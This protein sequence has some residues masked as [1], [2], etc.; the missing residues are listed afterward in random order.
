METVSTWN[1]HF[2]LKSFQ[3]F[4]H[5]TAGWFTTH[6]GTVRPQVVQRVALHCPLEWRPIRRKGSAKF[7]GLDGWKRYWLCC[8]FPWVQ[9][10]LR[11]SMGNTACL[12]GIFNQVPVNKVTSHSCQGWLCHV[13]PW[14]AR[15]LIGFWF[16]VISPSLF[17]FPM[18]AWLGKK[19][20]HLP[21]L[22]NCMT[23]SEASR[24]RNQ[25]KACCS[26]QQQSLQGPASMFESQPRLECCWR[27]P[28]PRSNWLRALVVTGPMPGVFSCAML[29][30]THHHGW[31]CLRMG[32]MENVNHVWW[33][34]WCKIEGRLPLK[35]GMPMSPARWKFCQIVG[36]I[37]YH[38]GW[39]L[40]TCGSCRQDDPLRD[41]GRFGSPR[42]PASESRYKQSNGCRHIIE[43]SKASLVFLQ[44]KVKDT[45][46][47]P[48]IP[49]APVYFCHHR[50][51]CGYGT[52]P[53]WVAFHIPNGLQNLFQ[54]VDDPVEFV[55][56]S[57][58]A[59]PNVRW[60]SF[61]CGQTSTATFAAHSCGPSTHW[62]HHPLTQ[63]TARGPTSGST[64]R[65]TFAS[66]PARR[67]VH[68]GFWAEAGSGGGS[69]WVTMG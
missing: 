38:Y 54:F 22:M 31:H 59:F 13:I 27:S 40:A 23:G 57:L 62:C 7:L 10:L 63:R 12:D 64:K 1:W 26:P 61:C 4:Q 25:R 65:T 6:H 66:S 8:V 48:S 11:R 43:R 20:C 2:G 33:G 60:G 37:G 3:Q 9:P 5:Y 67:A 53:T 30:W 44:A 49:C 39:I 47:S 21:S 51:Q 45:S 17:S 32:K 16:I 35:I 52:K 42:N 28:I 69:C 34:V 56:H 18:T 41:E 58:S 29:G 19:I 50:R 46:S 14:F 36:V 24:L 15:V 68:L 55:P